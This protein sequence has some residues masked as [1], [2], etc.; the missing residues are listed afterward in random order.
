M[1][2][3]WRPPHYETI[4]E[5]G[6]PH[7]RVFK[8]NCIIENMDFTE[9]GVGKSKRLAKRKAAQTMIKRLKDENLADSDDVAVSL[10]SLLLTIT[11]E[12][13]SEQR[14]NCTIRKIPL[15]LMI[16]FNQK[17]LVK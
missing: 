8:M 2:K 14:I 11:F 13:P 1:K 17:V 9:T 12:Y 6:L 16:G 15:F 4:S 7:E 3:H 10:T 5:E